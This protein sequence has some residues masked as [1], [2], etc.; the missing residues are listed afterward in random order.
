MS[1]HLRVL[2]QERSSEYQHDR[3]KLVLIDLS[4]VAL[5]TKVASGL[6][7]LNDEV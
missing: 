6:G 2:K 7:G 1:N 5:W 4:V 3:V